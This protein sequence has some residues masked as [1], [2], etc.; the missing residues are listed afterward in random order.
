MKPDETDEKIIGMLRKDSRTSNVAI[1]GRLGLTEG[2][3]RSR[4]KK[5]VEGKVIR[6]FS[7]DLAGTASNF[8]LL[9]V[10]AK[11]ET[12]KLMSAVTSL[13]IHHDAYEISGEFDA[14]IILEGSSVEAIDRKIDRIRALKEVS[15]TKTH[16][17]FRH[18]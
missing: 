14:C 17:A 8:A 1:A 5:L 18:W 9:M 3:V 15:G 12:K 2:A 6:R 10:K 16:I 13:G 4:I 11:G 7:V